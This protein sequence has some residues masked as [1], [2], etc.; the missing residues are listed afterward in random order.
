MYHCEGGFRERER[1]RE[2]ERERER[3]RDRNYPVQILLSRQDRLNG[4][5]IKTGPSESL[6][7]LEIIYFSHSSVS[8]HLSRCICLCNCPS[9]WVS[10]PCLCLCLSLPLSIGRSIDRSTMKMS[11]FYS[12]LFSLIVSVINFYFFPVSTSAPIGVN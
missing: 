12:D 7:K 11:C 1:K 5:K 3:E 10:N 9:C 6:E 2:R 8:L 4:R